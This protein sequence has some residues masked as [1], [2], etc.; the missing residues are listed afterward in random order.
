MRILFLVRALARAG[1]ERQLVNLAIGLHRYGH[2]VRVVT[3]YP[4]G[5]LEED[6]LAAGVPVESLG[7]KGRW[8]VFR[9][10]LRLVRLIKREAPDVVHGYMH[11]NVLTVPLKVLFPRTCCVWGIR[12]SDMDLSR[13]EWLARLLESIEPKLS[14]F[15]D[16][17]IVN[18][19]AGRDSAICRG[20]TAHQMIVIPNGIDVADFYPD[21]PAGAALRTRWGLT[22]Q[23]ILIGRIGRLDPQK[24]YPTFFAAAAEFKRRFPD[25]RFLC[26]GEGP[27]NIEQEL[28][29]LAARLDLTENLIFSGL[30]GEMRSVYNA[31]SILTSSSAWE[32]FPNVVAEALACGVP[33]V[34][35]DVGDT[36]ILV[37]H[38]EF[39]V[40]PR[41]PLALANAWEKCLRYHAQWNAQ[42]ARQRIVTNYNLQNLTRHTE[43]ALLTASQ[44][45]V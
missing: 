7:K 23:D 17:I 27:R 30:R 8:D 1:A 12:S 45:S 21:R 37:G 20:Y 43:A 2:V 31:L 16:L 32:G 29:A 14:Q 13:Y 36:K 38:P 3:F 33:C 26:M 25:V 41:N 22:P 42:E 4:G 34:A 28:K 19:R 39:V 35:T 5:P 11:A 40:P 44:N 9:F 18:S 10:V 15:A 24:D 6:L